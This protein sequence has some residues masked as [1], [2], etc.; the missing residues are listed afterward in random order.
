MSMSLIRLADGQKFE[1]AQPNEGEGMLRNRKRSTVQITF[2][3]AAG[4]FDSIR[5]AIVPENLETFDIFYPENETAD[6]PDEQLEGVSHKTFEGY[7][8]VGDWEDK[9]I[10][11]QKETSKTMAVYG[12]QLSVTLGERLASDT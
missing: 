6:E 10:E 5:A 7:S 9:E 3:A 8:L 11:V 12:R 2:R 4:Q 1:I